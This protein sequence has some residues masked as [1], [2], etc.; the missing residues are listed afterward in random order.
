MNTTIPGSPANL[1]KVASAEPVGANTAAPATAPPSPTAPSA[2]S[3][4]TG[5]RPSTAL[6]SI[7][8]DGSLTV[9]DKVAALLLLITQQM[10][11]QI[12][13]QADTV[14]QLAQNTG[15]PGSE[16]QGQPKTNEVDT[17]VFKLQRFTEKRKQMFDMLKSIVK[18]YD[19][20][21]KGVI[22][23]IGAR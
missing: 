8:A 11:E 23:D 18:S 10:D 1:P 9:A 15:K 4:A 20:S 6:T 3:A 17:E 16:M 12:E 22:R 2:P 14:A 5:S 21:T 13:A 7:L 19:D